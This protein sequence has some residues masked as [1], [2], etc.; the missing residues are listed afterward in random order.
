MAL[1]FKLLVISTIICTGFVLLT[2][3][4]IKNVFEVKLESWRAVALTSIIFLG[5]FIFNYAIRL[6]INKIKSNQHMTQIDRIIW[7]CILLVGVLGLA[8]A[9]P[10]SAIYVFEL[11]VYDLG[12]WIITGSTIVID[13]WFAIVF[14]SNLKKIR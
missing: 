11:D 9:A 8:I 5:I 2:P 3:A 14:L 10:L 13:S 1:R 7:I 4:I 6:E 12:F